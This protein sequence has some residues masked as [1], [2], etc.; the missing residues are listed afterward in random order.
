M[1]LFKDTIH[2]EI[3]LFIKLKF[4]LDILAYAL[5]QILHT[6]ILVTIVRVKQCAEFIFILKFISIHHEWGS[7]KRQLQFV[8]KLF[9]DIVFQEVVLLLGF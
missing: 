8:C 2:K 6:C 1:E 5:H 4:R 7:Q 3:Q 9:H